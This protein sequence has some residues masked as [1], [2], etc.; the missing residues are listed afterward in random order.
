MEE[1]QM[2]S[3]SFEPGAAA[4]KLFDKQEIEFE[5]MTYGARMK[6]ERRIRIKIFNEKGYPQASIKIPY[7]NKKILW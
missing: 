5:F 2:N 3:C 7:L 6:T 1:L 4:M